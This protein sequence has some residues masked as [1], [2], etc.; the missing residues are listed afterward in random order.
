MD[1][2]EFIEKYCLIKTKNGEIKHI[3]LKN[4]QKQFINEITKE[5]KCK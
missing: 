5:Q 2:I 3:K 4:Y 1:K